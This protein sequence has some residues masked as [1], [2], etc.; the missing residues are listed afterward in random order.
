MWEEVMLMRFP[1]PR[2][3]TQKK[4]K[5][6]IYNVLHNINKIILKSIIIRY[7]INYFCSN[8]NSLYMYCY[9]FLLSDKLTLKRI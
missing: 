7:T 9:Y 8:N 5:K 2:A 1:P 4:K 3:I 6:G